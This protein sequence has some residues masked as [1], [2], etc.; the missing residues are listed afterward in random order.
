M[1]NLICKK[2]HKIIVAL[3]AMRSHFLF[4]IRELF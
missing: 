4:Q 2:T 3:F 1:S